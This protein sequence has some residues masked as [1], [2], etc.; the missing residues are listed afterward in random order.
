LRLSSLYSTGSISSSQMDQVDTRAAGMGHQVEA[1]LASE[2]AARARVDA[3]FRSQLAA[4]AQ[5]DTARGN[6]SAVEAGVRRAEIAVQECK[7]VAPRAG[8]V[9]SRNYEPGEVVLPGAHVL[10]LVDLNEVKSTFYLPNAE[11]AAAAPGKR[12]SVRADAWPSDTF[13]G[14]IRHV[15]S[16]A[17]FT[18][19]N[20]QTREDRDRLVYGVEVVLANPGYKL[21]PGMPVEV[22]IEGTAR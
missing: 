5:I 18:P 14:S 15:S 8:V 2:K 6:V 19:R 3:A 7:L 17:E 21:R 1:M 12:V 11:L 20:V 10:T 9:Q 4:G 13:A 22:V 16:K